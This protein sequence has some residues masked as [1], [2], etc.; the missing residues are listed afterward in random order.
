MN[1]A[2]I[3]GEIALRIALAARALPD[4]EPRRLLTVLD[5]AVGLPPTE[6][7]LRALKIKELKRAADGELADCPSGDLKHALAILKGEQETMDMPLPEVDAY[8]EGDMPDSIRV[9]C[10][11]NV[12]EQLNGHF[13][14]CQRFLIYQVSATA[15]RLIAIRPALESPVVEDKN[16]YRAGLIDDCQV[17]YV[18]SIGGPP[19]AKVVRAGIHPIKRPDGGDARAAVQELQ[20]VLAE[21]PPPWL[22]KIMGR[23]PEARVRFMA[24]GEA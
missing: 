11:S 10:A 19:A 5:D 16:Q 1:D 9:A 22:A 8:V 13:G 14:S 21:A 18:M 4:T 7:K 24:E 23:A 15:C 2:P 3:S 12:G 17:L 6:P 20:P